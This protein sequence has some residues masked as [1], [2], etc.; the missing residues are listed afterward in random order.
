MT[1]GHHIA[2]IINLLIVFSCCPFCILTEYEGAALKTQ[3]S[4]SFLNFGQ[5]CIFSAAL[6]AAMVMCAKGIMDGSMTIGDLVSLVQ[7]KAHFKIFVSFI[8]QGPSVI[9]LIF[10][11]AMHL[12]GN[13]TDMSPHD[14]SISYMAAVICNSIFQQANL[15]CY[16]FD[17]ENFHGF[18]FLGQRKYNVVYARNTP[19]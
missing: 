7:G 17:K 6:S 14:Y 19:L 3:S 5:N 4:L 15:A 1:K 8:F 13:D 16:I 9:D 10:N 11:Q 18:L 12:K 2:G